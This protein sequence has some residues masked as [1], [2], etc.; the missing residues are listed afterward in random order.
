MNLSTYDINSDMIEKAITK[1]TKAIMLVHPLGHVCNMNKI[2][3]IC[4][5]YKLLL[6][7]DTCETLGAKYKNK[8]A[9]TFGKFSSIS[10]Y[11]SLIFLRLRVV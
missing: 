4:K 8:F 1:K 6:I 9:G 7:E 11:Q 2:L 10:F 3:K 5:K